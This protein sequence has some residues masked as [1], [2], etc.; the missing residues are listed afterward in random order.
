MALLVQS[1]VPVTL[2]LDRITTL[3][4]SALL[5]GLDPATTP[6]LGA[7][8]FDS[9]GYELESVAGPRFVIEPGT[10]TLHV[11][12][13]ENWA[14]IPVHAQEEGDEGPVPSARLELRLAGLQ[15]FS[16][17]LT[18][19]MPTEAASLQG[20]DGDERVRVEL[21]DVDA[22]DTV[23]YRAGLGNDRVSLTGGMGVVEGGDGDD[24]LWGAS[25]D[26]GLI[27]QVGADMLYGGLGA[28]RLDGGTGN[29]RLFGG[30][31]NDLL[32]GGEG[33]DD[34][35]G[36][37]GHD[38]L[39]GGMGVNTLRGEAGNDR[40]EL[41][42][43]IR[44]PMGP[45]GFATVAFGGDGDDRFV[46]D[47]TV[48]VDLGAFGETK[49]YATLHGG[50]GRDRIDL[51]Q[52]ESGKFYGGADNDYIY[53]EQRQE[54]IGSMEAFGGTG[55]D[56]I[57]LL[58]NANIR[59]GE[60]NDFISGGPFATIRGE[61]G[62]DT[63]ELYG[64]ES[65]TDV[66]TGGLVYGGA[67]NDRITGALHDD[68]LLGGAGNDTIYGGLG[69]DTLNGGDDNDVLA[70]GALADELY[71]GLGA[72][73]LRAEDD[74]YYTD[75]IIQMGLWS[76]ADTLYGGAGNDTLTADRNGHS[77]YGEEGDD[78]IQ[79]FAEVRIGTDSSQ[80]YGGIGN[81]T[82]EATGWNNVY[83][84]AGEDL[85]VA[86]VEDNDR[87]NV[88]ILQDFVQGEDLIDVVDVR[89]ETP[90]WLSDMAVNTSGEGTSGLLGGGVPSLSW[91][92][93]SDN[94]GTHIFFDTDG[95]S[96]ADAQMIVLGVLNLSVTDLAGYF[97]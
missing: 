57:V 94:A 41:G 59:G 87:S 37:A 95:D 17:S 48:L 91:S 38:V 76:I 4:L 40:F 88:Y 11:L 69:I 13:N 32:I 61:N 72:D 10:Y 71:G 1:D 49:G 63:I 85:F 15:L 58:G 43:Q 6:L 9:Y 26:D 53:V 50:A 33:N 96:I 16:V 84:G 19:T 42:E 55:D 56:T 51:G 82:I 36:G 22:T 65:A 23:V 7:A 83:G 20:T 86:R 39:R 28:D 90:V 77:L 66:P 60:G 27:G 35:R 14:G 67:G 52:V 78:L 97:D 70:G 81:D 64:D 93:Y 8:Y 68:S 12:P 31:G 18:P 34:M 2:A 92:I 30:A 80:I 73:E 3:D 45:T 29:D 44:P 47:T 75:D 62:D 46:M 21:A 25:G 5:E 24:S 89:G 54:R 74:R 79:V